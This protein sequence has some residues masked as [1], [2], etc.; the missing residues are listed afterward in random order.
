MPE[1]RDVQDEVKN[2]KHPGRTAFS[3]N[4]EPTNFPEDHAYSR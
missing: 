4:D 2:H 3:I 1:V